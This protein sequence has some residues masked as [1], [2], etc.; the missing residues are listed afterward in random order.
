[1]EK[2]LSPFKRTKIFPSRK[3]KV[4]QLETK[5]NNKTSSQTT[6]VQAKG[7][8]SYT[9]PVDVTRKVF[10]FHGRTETL[11]FSLKRGDACGSLLPR[12]YQ[13]QLEIR[14]KQMDC[15]NTLPSSCYYLVSLSFVPS[16]LAHIVSIVCAGR[17]LQT[18]LDSLELVDFPT[19]RR[20]PGV[21]WPIDTR[22]RWSPSNERL[23]FL[24]LYLSGL[25]RF[26]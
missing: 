2:S 15:E 19:E 21:I 14:S 9:S 26:T 10:L 13:R 12:D 18:D 20:Q 7:C 23:W 17:L 3:N 1:M 25:V 24:V 16:L 22:N 5:S 8:A 6:T 4:T 11:G